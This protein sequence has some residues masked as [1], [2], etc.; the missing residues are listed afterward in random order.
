[1]PRAPAA[2][3]VVGAGWAGLAA[4]VRAAGEAGHGHAVRDG[5]QPGAAARAAWRRHGL[6]NGQH[7]LIG[8]YR[9]TLA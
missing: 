5:A 6:D 2:A 9:A 3:A 8:A 1:V 7:I 4:A